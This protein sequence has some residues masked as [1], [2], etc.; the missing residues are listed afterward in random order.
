MIPWLNN[1]FLLVLDF[2]YHNTDNF[3]IVA[4]QALLVAFLLVRENVKEE[5]N[6]ETF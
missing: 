6:Q 3:H 5:H 4:V 2:N 1:G